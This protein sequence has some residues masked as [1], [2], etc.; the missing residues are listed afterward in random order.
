LNLFKAYADDSITSPPDNEFFCSS[1]HFHGLNGFS[2]LRYRFDANRYGEASRQIGVLRDK[3]AAAGLT[4]QVIGQDVIV[5]GSAAFGGYYALPVASAAL[6]SGGT[7]GAQAGSPGGP[8]F[9]FVGAMI[10][11]A[12]GIAFSVSAYHSAQRD[13]E[14]ELAVYRSLFDRPYSS[15]NPGGYVNWTDSE[16]TW[17]SAI[18]ETF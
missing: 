6:A 10:G 14:K 12:V 13:Y 3:Q 1:C 9:A 17:A 4:G 18:G 7:A 5:T 15:S 8:V 2:E 16:S 11:A